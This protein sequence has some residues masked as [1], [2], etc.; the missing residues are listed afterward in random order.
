MCVCL[1]SGELMSCRLYLRELA[2]SSE[3]GEQGRGERGRMGE[4]E[5]EGLWF[6]K[7]DTDTLLPCKRTTGSSYMCTY[8]VAGV[9]YLFL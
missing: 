7:C 2:D 8:T 4:W 9:C 5:H 6:S 1:T 3:R